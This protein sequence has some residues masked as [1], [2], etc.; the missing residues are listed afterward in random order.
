VKTFV[1]S[2]VSIVLV[3]VGF[4]IGQDFSA[5]D[6]FSTSSSAADSATSDYELNAE[7]DETVYHQIVT[8]GWGTRDMLE[9]I[10]NQTDG[11]DKMAEQ[12]VQAQET[13]VRLQVIQIFLIGLLIAAVLI[14]FPS[15]I[16]RSGSAPRSISTIPA[17]ASK[18]ST[19]P[20]QLLPSEYNPNCQCS[21]S[22][23][24]FGGKT[25]TYGRDSCLRCGKKIVDK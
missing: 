15:A 12:L 8:G 10:A 21:V 5:P 25:I 13:Q 9:V 18:E 16:N 17:E 11:L 7:N 2:V 22:A 24:D 14:V 4:F 3:A 20:D 6:S 23:R 19:D 1:L